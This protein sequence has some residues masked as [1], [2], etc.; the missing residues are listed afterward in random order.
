M[1]PSVPISLRFPQDYSTWGNSQTHA[2]ILFH[3]FLHRF[4]IRTS[5]ISDKLASVL[6]AMLLADNGQSGCPSCSVIFT[7]RGTTSLV[8]GC[9]GLVVISKDLLPLKIAI[10]S[11]TVLPR[12]YLKGVEVK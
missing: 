10:N 9:A 1:L 4:T 2:G 11:L 6:M 12:H 3:V 8:L 7:Y 5:V